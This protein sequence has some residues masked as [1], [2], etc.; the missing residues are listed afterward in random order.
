MGN[1]IY[2]FKVVVVGI[3]ALTPILLAAKAP[4]P[5]QFFY[6]FVMGTAFV[7]ILLVPKKRKYEL[8]F[9]CLLVVGLW[10]LR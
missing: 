2:L 1:I 7:G 5:E 3:G 8:A 4:T 9:Y 10:S 6:R